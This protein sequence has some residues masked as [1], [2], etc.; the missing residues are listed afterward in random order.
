MFVD[1]KDVK[2]NKRKDTIIFACKPVDWSS[3]NYLDPEQAEEVDF[4]FR[5]PVSHDK[6]S[7]GDLECGGFNTEGERVGRTLDRVKK[8][9]MMYIGTN[10][11]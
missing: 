9:K 6:L 3:I 2:G 8:V 1:I 5:L 4:Y 11:I 10:P 7:V